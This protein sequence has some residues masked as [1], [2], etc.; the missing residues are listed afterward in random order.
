MQEKGAD[1]QDA[2]RKNKNSELSVV[3]PFWLF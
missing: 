3:D 2:Q 1:L